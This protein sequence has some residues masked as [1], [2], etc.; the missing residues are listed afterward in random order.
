M[1][2]HRKVELAASRRIRHGPKHRVTKRDRSS[3]KEKI[4]HMP[5]TTDINGD[6]G[7]PG[8]LQ[9]KRRTPL[10]ALTARR[11]RLSVRAQRQGEL[12]LRKH[13]RTGGDRTTDEW[14]RSLVG[15]QRR[16]GKR[17]RRRDKRARRRDCGLATGVLVLER[18]WHAC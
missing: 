6:K 12:G 14:R 8:Q 13:A 1:L 3:C 15:E 18:E 11:L 2:F 9:G 7:E 5:G 10:L 16:S 17:A 4:E